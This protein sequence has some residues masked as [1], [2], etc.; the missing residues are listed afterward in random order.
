MSDQNSVMVSLTIDDKDISVPKGTLVVEAAKLLDTEIPVFCYHPKLESIGACRLCMVEIGLPVIDRATGEK[1]LEADGS[2]K[3]NFGKGQVTSCTTV[4][5]EGMVVRTQTDGVKKTRADMLEFLLTCD[6][7]GE[8]PLQDLT[9]TYGHDTSRM[10][11]Q[12]KIRLDKRVP[13]GELIVLDK[14]RCIQCAR[15]IRFQDEV[16]DDPV[17]EFHMRGRR[18]EIVTFSDPGFDRQHL[19]RQHDRYLSGRSADH[20]RLPLWGATMG[21]EPGGQYL[22]PLPG[23]LQH[24]HGYPPRGRFRRS[25][26]HQTHFAAAERS[27]Q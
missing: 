2:V 20:I 12:D 27:R 24:H 16:A 13:L 5:S 3:L 15:C 4:V 22:L 11:F 18:L 1:V 21:T 9:M 7:G 14:E 6:K 17:I 10:D 23:G 26:R 19:G 8:C 25:A